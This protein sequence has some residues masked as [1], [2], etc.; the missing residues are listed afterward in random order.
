MKMN[1]LMPIEVECHSG[2]KADEYPK[3]FYLS[4]EKYEI[5][6]IIDRWYQGDKNPEWPLAD[7]FKVVTDNNKTFIIKHELTSNT[8]T[9]VKQC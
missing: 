1:E 9:L 6:E 7:Y 5:V 3:C 4:D 8:W 2:Y